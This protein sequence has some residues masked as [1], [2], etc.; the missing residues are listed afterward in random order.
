[1]SMG[2]GIIASNLQQIGEILKH[3][4]TAY[5]VEPGDP[6]RLADALAIL[7]DDGELRKRLGRAA[8]AEVL[9]NFTWKEHTRKIVEKL[10]ALSEK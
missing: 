2:K 1:M 8:R 10:K 9:A 6:V 7:A 5:M 3:D 4:R